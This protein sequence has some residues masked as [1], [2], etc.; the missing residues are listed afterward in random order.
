MSSL[1]L[2]SQGMQW[3]SCIMLFITEDWGFLSLGPLKDCKTANLSTK[4]PY[5]VRTSSTH[6]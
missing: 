4:V 3:K 5:E 6:A 1:F 2:Q